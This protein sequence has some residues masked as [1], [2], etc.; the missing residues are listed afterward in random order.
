MSFLLRL[1]ARAMGS[2][3]TPLLQPKDRGLARAW[4]PT[5]ARAVEEPPPEDPADDTAAPARATRVARAITTEATGWDEEEPEV[6]TT[7]G[8]VAR[9]TEDAAEEPPPGEDEAVRPARPPA[10]DDPPSE[11]TPKPDE[12]ADDPP[13]SQARARREAAAPP[14]PA[15]APGGELI[16][17]SAPAAV[18]AGPN[19]TFEPDAANPATPFEPHFEAVPFAPTLPSWPPAGGYRPASGPPLERPQVI[20]E[21]VDVLIHEPAPAMAVD[22][23]ARDRRRSLDARYLRRL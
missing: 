13:P 12:L 23:S 5:L 22:H 7:D 3:G 1:T 10:P 9:A 19:A 16:S 21:Q 18:V 17:Y 4:R 2:G 20:V 14:A 6:A 11:D 8:T 15:M